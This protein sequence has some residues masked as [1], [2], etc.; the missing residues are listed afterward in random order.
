ME[1]TFLQDSKHS[2]AARSLPVVSQ[3]LE[4][5]IKVLE[6]LSRINKTNDNKSSIKS[7]SPSGSF[8]SGDP[9]DL[10]IRENNFNFEERLVMIL[11]LAPH[12]NPETLEMFKIE[13]SPPTAFGGIIGK[14]RAFIPT[15]ETIMFILAG[16]DIQKRL[17]LL[18]LFDK[19][20]VFYRENLVYLEDPAPG[21]PE[22][23]GVLTPSKDLI[24]LAMRGQVRKPDLSPDFPAKLITTEMDWEDLVVPNHTKEQLHEIEQWI[25]CSPEL[26]SD[27][28]LGKKLKAG[29]KALFYGPPGTGKT[30]AAT[31]IGKK[32]GRDVY[33]ID[34]ST[35]VSKYIG[36]TEKNLRKLFD[37]AERK[38][39]ILFF[40][41]ADALFGKRTS[42]SDAHDRYA[43]QEVSYLLQRIEHFDGMVILA[44]NMKNNIDNAFMR[45]FQNI[46]HFPIPKAD[47]RLAL[48]KK[49]LPEKITLDK[50]VDLQKLANDHELTGAH[51]VNIVSHCALKVVANGTRTLSASLIRASIAR[52]LGKEGRTL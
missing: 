31:L 26:A 6:E 2:N 36:E 9:Y 32:T 4:W 11:S 52:E 42:V 49:T 19:D 8:T 47:E 24:D 1:T 40:D 45:R 3:E 48:W 10:L 12:V 28:Q 30:L 25:T 20:H 39:W 37:R 5:L 17:E 34:L 35:V 51:I 18:K 21:E 27:P 38:N 16:N 7:I 44:T 46:V 23:S 43:N 13:K 29:F 14:N 15:G 22:L 33:R 41:E 50:T